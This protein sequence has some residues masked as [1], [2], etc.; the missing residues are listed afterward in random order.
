MSELIGSFLQILPWRPLH[1]LDDIL[2]QY[3]ALFNCFNAT[4]EGWLVSPLLLSIIASFTAPGPGILA[5]PQDL[6][7]T[8]ALPLSRLISHSTDTWSK[9][10]NLLHLIWLVTY[11]TIIFPVQDSQPSTLFRVFESIV[12]M[13]QCNSAYCTVR[14]LLHKP[15]QWYTNKP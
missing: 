9:T 7:Q 13:S 10:L 11:S 8:S 12:T 5:Q 2:G 14:I 15:L 4:S 1:L 3:P 6:F